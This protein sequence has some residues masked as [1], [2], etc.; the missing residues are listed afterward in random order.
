M[1]DRNSGGHSMD[2]NV[3]ALPAALAASLGAYAH[4]VVGNRWLT[5]HLRSTETAR[6]AA[7]T[8]LFGARDVS[9]QVLGLTWHALTAVFLASA[10][11]LYLSVVGALDSRDLLRFIAV[12]NAAFLGVGLIYVRGFRRLLRLPMPALFFAGVLTGALFSWIASNSA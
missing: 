7:S 9:R 5:A 6:T 8:R 12:I 1:D 10:V 3:A 2:A 4:G 11:A